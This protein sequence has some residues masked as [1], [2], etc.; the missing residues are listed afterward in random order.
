MDAGS[1]PANR[2]DGTYPAGTD[3]RSRHGRRDH[4]CEWTDRDRA[5]RCIAGAGRHGRDHRARIG[6][7][8]AVGPDGGD[9][10][11]RRARRRRRG[12]A[13]RGREPR[14]EEV[15]AGAEGEDPREPRPG[16]RAD[17]DHDRRVRGEAGG[18][19]VGERGRLLRRPGRRGTH[20]GERTAAPG[21]LPLRRVRGVGGGDGQRRG[22]RHPHGAPAHRDRVEQGRRRAR[23]H[24]AAVQ[25]RARWPDRL[26]PPV[27]ELGL[28]RRRGRRD[29]P[30]D[31]HRRAA[32]SA[33][34][35]RSGAGHQRRVH[36]GA[37]APRCI[38]RP[39]CRRRWHR[40]RWS[41][42]PSSCSASWS[43]AN[44]CSRRRSR[45]A[46]TSSVTPRIDAAFA[47]V[48]A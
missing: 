13:P 38:A 33:R 25:A 7:R 10:R 27:H 24:A 18:A 30:R 46:A 16:Y 17:R 6:R 9:D 4:R 20:R 15:D 34:R 44:G 37:R 39:C 41:T 8:R 31:R 36:E 32:R 22:G 1:D 45:R 47:A 14:R 26:R 40:S 12:G 35:H 29:P 11:R 19:G 42:A 3:P 28:D 5:R 48:L 43:R 23:P 2:C 21:Q